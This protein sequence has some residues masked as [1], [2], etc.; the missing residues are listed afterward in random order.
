MDRLGV[1]PKRIDLIFISHCHLDHVGGRKDASEQT[2]SL[3]RGQVD[4]PR[5]PVYAPV[6]LSP[7]SSNTSLFGIEVTEPKILKP[8]IASIG[9]M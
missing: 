6:A 9:P 7:S 4:L 8:G 3:S 5:I 1:D 2:F